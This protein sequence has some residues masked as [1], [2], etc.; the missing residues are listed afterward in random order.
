MLTFAHVTQSPPC[1]QGGATVTRRLSPGGARTF[2]PSNLGRW[3]CHHTD[4]TFHSNMSL[5]QLKYQKTQ[6]CHHFVVTSLAAGSGD[7]CPSVC[8]CH[9]ITSHCHSWYLICPCVWRADDITC[10]ICHGNSCF[11]LFIALVNFSIFGYLANLEAKNKS[12]G[13]TE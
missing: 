5:V 8:C 3:R 7:A 9:P 12:A 2:Q 10:Y 4:R 11:S 1:G 6:R 13:T